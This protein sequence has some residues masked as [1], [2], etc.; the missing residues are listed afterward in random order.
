MKTVIVI[1]SFK[2][3]LTSL[4]AGKAAAEGVRLAHPQAE[5]VVF[6]V[7]DGGEGTVEA[8]ISGLG[9]E[10]QQVQ[11]CDPLGRRISCTYG[12]AGKVAVME[13][14][15]AAGITLITDGEKNPMHTTTYG[16]G[17]M[18][19]HGIE[20]GCR[21]FIIGIGGSATNDCGIGML[22]AL[23]FEILDKEG[24]PVPFGAEGVAKAAYIRTEK[25]L[26][27]LKECTFRIACDVENPLCGQWGC[28]AVYGPQKGATPQMVKEMDESIATFA[29]LAKAT[30]PDA[31]PDAPGAGAAGGLGFAFLTFL[32][33]KLEKGV[34]L[35]LSALGVEKEIRGADY[36]LT[37]EGRLDAQT[38][39]GKVPSGVARLAAK[40][41]VPVL[42]FA[43]SVAEGA[44][45]CN[46]KGILAYFP[47]LQKP[48]TLQEAMDSTT[49]RENMK[50]TV[51]QVF[52]LL[53]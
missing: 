6:P 38:V 34:S 16:V 45:V 35:V 46:Q 52:R 15:A 26:P 48:C 20:N 12:K 17:E 19:V 36:V 47:I 31:D 8:L 30:F 40:H 14:S 27:Q 1:D 37:G 2:G 32:G 21:D 23:G 3:S 28:S 29:H 10:W 33:G 24:T 41:N 44:K 11:A 4:D 42:A 49:A 9:G 13:M 22:Q 53:K 18:I 39:M 43:G 7:A 50:K 5:T 25:V 51:E